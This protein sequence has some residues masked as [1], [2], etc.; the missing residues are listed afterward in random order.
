MGRLGDWVLSRQ[1]FS[2]GAPDLPQVLAVHP[3][4]Q[5]LEEFLADLFRLGGRAYDSALWAPSKDGGYEYPP[6]RGGP[7][8]RYCLVRC[9]AAEP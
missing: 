7:H 8:D 4:H 6:P 5:V 2:A 9:Q 3:S 1:A